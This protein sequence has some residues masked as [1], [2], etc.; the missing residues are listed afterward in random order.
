MAIRVSSAP[1][2]VGSRHH[3]PVKFES[4]EAISSP[5]LAA[6]ILNADFGH[7][8]DQLAAAEHA[9]VDWIHVD[10][11]D[12]LFVPNLSMG[13]PILEAVQRATALPVDVHLMIDRPERFIGRFAEAGA[14]YLTIHQESTAQLYRT[15]A[16]VRSAG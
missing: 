11:M 1:G 5:R 12:G 15:L 16:E 3:D 9:G 10:V 4:R 6:S 7:L 2:S 8:A 14:T 13:F